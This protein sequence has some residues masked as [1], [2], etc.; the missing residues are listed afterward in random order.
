M[1]RIVVLLLVFLAG[2]LVTARAADRDT[3]VQFSTIDALLNGKAI[4]IAGG[5]FEMTFSRF[6]CRRGHEWD[7]P[8]EI[9][10][11]TTPELCPTCRTPGTKTV[12]PAGFQ[13][14]GRRKGRRSA[15]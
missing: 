12:L 9:A 1:K 2:P 10:R 13:G 11:E 5:N 7:T 3:I 15:N 6:R 14:G 8:V 4:R